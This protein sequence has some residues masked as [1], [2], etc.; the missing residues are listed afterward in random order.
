[1]I[2]GVRLYVF[3]KY[4]WC[5]EGFAIHAAFSEAALAFASEGKLDAQQVAALHR[6][7]KSV[8]FLLPAFEKPF[9]SIVH[10]PV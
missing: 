9:P 4:C 10:I 7:L 1:M 2:S 5:A 6:L 3:C 8:S